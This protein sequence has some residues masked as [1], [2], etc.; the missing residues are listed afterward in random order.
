MR[1]FTLIETLL[2][3]ALVG[4]VLGAMVL[5]MVTLLTA[6]SKSQ[7]TLTLEENVRFALEQMVG[8]IQNASGIVNPT[9]SGA[10]TTITLNSPNPQRN[11]TTITL[12]D[13]S[14]L[15]TESAAPAVALTGSHVEVTELT[16]ERLAGTPPSVH[17][18]L[19]AQTRSTQGAS[20]A[21]ISTRLE[22]TAT[23]RR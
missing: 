6:H 5:A 18:H 8:R 14:I 21:V 7:A 15:V 20:R 3:T 10:A 9:G 11:P 17:I 1:G 16:F 2:Y 12:T 13:G 22:T 19:T 23:V 4:I